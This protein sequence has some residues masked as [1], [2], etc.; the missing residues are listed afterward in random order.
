MKI[1]F[2]GYK[3]GL[4]EA[5]PEL[6]EVI[7]KKKLNIELICSSK[8]LESIQDATLTLCKKRYMLRKQFLEKLKKI[9]KAEQI[10]SLI[11]YEFN[12]A[13]AAGYKKYDVWTEILNKNI[14]NKCMNNLNLLQ[15]KKYYDIYHNKIRGITRFT[16]P[17]TIRARENLLDKNIL[18]TKKE[19]VNKVDDKLGN[20]IVS[21]KTF[22]KK[23]EKNNYDLV[24]NVSGP[25]NVEKIKNEIAL[26]KSLKMQ[27]A[28]VKSGGF[29][30]DGNFQ[31]KGIKNVYTVG[32]LARGFNP[33][34]KT[35]LKAI[36]ENSAIAGQSIA[37]TL[38]YI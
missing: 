32:I 13:V 24:I 19:I 35:I 26:V 6:K 4:L 30:V 2:I 18:K 37:K 17:E 1:Y 15:K 14:L 23:H 21:S 31:L 34:R 28:K 10:Y 8:N 5:L 20:L 22:A 9:H 3:A 36:L 33:E 25:L 27:G 7:L 16:Y 12:F 38:L 29:V 11:L